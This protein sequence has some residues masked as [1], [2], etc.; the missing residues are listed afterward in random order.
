M[1]PMRLRKFDP[2]STCW[3]GQGK[4]NAT[5]P[6]QLTRLLGGCAKKKK[7]HKNYLAKLNHTQ[8]FMSEIDGE[9]VNENEETMK[10]SSE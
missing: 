9:L 3:I 10:G 4:G 1:Q 7:N 8:D 5:G 6:W 2:T